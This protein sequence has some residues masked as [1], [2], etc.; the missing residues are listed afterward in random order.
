[1]LIRRIRRSSRSRLR[2][3]DE[4]RTP[5]TAPA[6]LSRGFR[7]SASS[8]R[9]MPA[10]PSAAIENKSA[11]HEFCDRTHISSCNP[12]D[13]KQIPAIPD[14]TKATQLNPQKPEPWSDCLEQVCA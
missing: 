9:A 5:S 10:P 13:A 7:Q 2:T 12:V 1:L 14:R 3:S 8:R 4:D 11:G 6:M